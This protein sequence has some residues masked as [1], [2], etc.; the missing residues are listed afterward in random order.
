[1]RSACR[2][3]RGET[4]GCRGA[5]LLSE[6]VEGVLEVWPHVAVVWQ[7]TPVEPLEAC[8]RRLHDAVVVGHQRAVAIGGERVA[9]DCGVVTA[10]VPPLGHCAEREADPGGGLNALA[11][12]RPAD[13]PAAAV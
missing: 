13:Q 12:S 6:R 7:K 3:V 10:R 8:Q 9:P 1:M 5:E 4:L 11:G 2:T